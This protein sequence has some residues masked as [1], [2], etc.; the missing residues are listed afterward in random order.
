MQ[1]PNIRNCIIPDHGMIL[2]EVD[3]KQA[4][5]QIVAWASDDAKL[6]S[7]FRQG[8]DIYTEQ[9]TGVWSDP[10]LPQSRQTRKNCVHS[11]NYGA[12][13]R[14]LA[15]RYV[16]SENAAKHFIDN[17]FTHHPAIRNWQRRIQWDLQQSHTPR[18]RNVFGY[19]R[20]Y[21]CVVPITQPLA[22]IGQSTVAR[23]NKQML[24]NYHAAA[25]SL[26]IQLLMPN[27]DSVLMQVDA[28]SCPDIFPELLRLARV[29]IPYDDPL[30]IPSELKW[31]DQS[32][33]HMEPWHDDERHF[34]T[35][36]DKAA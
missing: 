24:L 32:W 12:G 34:D 2:V 21:A 17:W 4:D 15:E 3:L 6:K 25:A 30:I 19:C 23:V 33:G 5:A 22:W 1:L 29:P 31:S 26:P 36:T 14:T 16:G 11:V 7:L 35:D 10:H 27:H 28:A 20:T 9:E 13:Y 18:I 8:I